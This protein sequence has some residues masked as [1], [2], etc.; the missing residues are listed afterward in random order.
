[1]SIKKEELRKISKR[2]IDNAHTE[3][4]IDTR[5][6]KAIEKYTNARTWK[7]AKFKKIKKIV[8]KQ[9]IPFIKELIAE[10]DMYNST[11]HS[12]LILLRQINIQ[13]TI[14]DLRYLNQLVIDTKPEIKKLIHILEYQIQAQNEQL[15]NKYIAEEREV[16][17]T[18]RENIKLIATKTDLIMQNAIKLPQFELLTKKSKAHAKR[19]IHNKQGFTSATTMKGIVGVGLAVSFASLL[20]VKYLH[21]LPFPDIEEYQ[22][23]RIEVHDPVPTAQELY[24]YL[25][26]IKDDGKIKRYEELSVD[27]KR[28]DGIRKSI[29]EITEHQKEITQHPPAPPGYEYWKT[30]QGIVTAYN[31]TGPGLMAGPHGH[32]EDGLTSRNKNAFIEDG[33]AIDPSLVPYGSKVYIPGV[34]FK[35][36]DDTGGRMR[37]NGARGIYHFDIRMGTY[38]REFRDYRAAL[39][40]GNPEKIAYYKKIYEQAQGN[41][42]HRALRWG[43]QNKEV[44]IY[45]KIGTGPSVASH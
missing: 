16:M 20:F 36:A 6:I 43:N 8:Q 11:A 32:Y 2:I 25:L 41:A 12:I 7:S 34:G 39:S 15:L 42:Y 31:P 37:Q 27:T 9:Q 33:V 35:I 24:G 13:K 45:R 18:I 30:V 28:L 14:D 1:M 22:S 4:A 40:E 38:E 29:S 3:Y 19:T 17:R 5:K 23:Q 44:V 26:D 10:I 21:S